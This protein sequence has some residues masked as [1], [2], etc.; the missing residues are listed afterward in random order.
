LSDEPPFLNGPNSEPDVDDQEIYDAIAENLDVLRSFNK[1]S[2]STDDLK[3]KASTES[4]LAMLYLRLDKFQDARKFLFLA[5][6]DYEKLQDKEQIAAIQGSIGS[7]DLHQGNYYSAKKYCE[8]AYQFWETSTHLNERIACMQN[9]GIIY[10]QMGDESKAVDTI[11]SAMRMAMKLQDP[12]QFAVTIQILLNYYE[13]HRKFDVLKE[14][15][16]KALEFWEKME[17][18][19]RQIKTLIDLGVISQVL[20]NY[21]DALQYFK[22]AYN[23]AYTSKDS[24]KMYLADGFIGETYFKLKE[25]EKAKQA[26]FD[27]FMLAVFLNLK[28]EIEK[29]RAVLV[30]LGVGLEEIKSKELEAKKTTDEKVST[31]KKSVN[32][33]NH[34]S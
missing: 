33:K 18:K 20:D 1:S 11:I 9:L 5:L 3:N 34:Q 15:K 23:L 19:P 25:I 29:M 2:D 6:G 30:T 4:Q 13:E 8:A 14:L 31:P 24:K 10:L 32:R 22:K 21:V 26:Y 16:L 12:D 7:L 17:L 28:E 27:A